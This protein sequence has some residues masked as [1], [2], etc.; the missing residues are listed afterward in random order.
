MRVCVWVPQ[1]V[2]DATPLVEALQR[3]H[4]PVDVTAVWAGDPHLRPRLPE[5]VR[6]S[7]LELPEPTGVG[8]GRLLVALPPDV[9]GWART[10]RALIRSLA[11]HGEPIVLLRGGSVGVQGSLAGLC[12]ASGATMVERSPDPIPDDGLAPSEG[13]L[14]RVGRWSD[15]AAAFA[16]DAV[17]LLD[18]LARVMAAGRPDDSAGSLLD[19]TV[20]RWAGPVCVAPD[21]VSAG[22]QVGPVA[23]TPH[24]VVVDE[25]DRDEPW[26]VRAG[27]DRPRTLLSG[28]P[29]LAATLTAT[30]AQWT[31]RAD[32]PVLPGGVPIDR[33]VRHLVHAAIDDWRRDA[34]ELPPQPFEG[35]GLLAWL[36]T[37][38]PE[39]GTGIG[40]YWVEEWRRR[41]DLH[42][43]FPDPAQADHAPFSHWARTSWRDGRSPLIRARSD[44]PTRWRDVGRDEG[45]NLIGHLASDLGLGEYARRILRALDAASVPTAVLHDERSS[46]PRSEDAPTT[47]DELRYDTN[48][49]VVRP[50]HL[51][52]LARDHG[53]EVFEGR[54]TIGYWFWELTHVP[55][56]VA[57]GAEAV[58]EIWVASEFVAD[59]F[60]RATTRPV[61]VVPIPI[62]EPALAELPRSHFSLPDDR[63]VFVVTFD[64]FSLTDR[65]N[66]FGAID[67]FGRA[68]PSSRPDGPILV[69]KTLNGA[70]RWLQHERL[71]LAAAGRDDIRVID[72]HL[73]RVEQMALVAASDALVSLHRSEGLGLHLMEAMW[74]GVP[75]IATRYSG[76]LQYMSDENAALVDARLVPVED[77]EGFYPPAA[78]WAEP[79][80]DAAASWMRRLVDDPSVGRAL[81]AAG[82]RTMMEQP[83]PAETGRLIAELARG[84]KEAS[85]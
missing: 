5:P 50:D 13:D 15:A 80:L 10:S 75:V 60:R 40:R 27:R 42:V 17:A 53:R 35:R 73:P 19:L 45:V 54:H 31:Y 38:A 64:H 72:G 33:V 79:D 4:D 58:D 65:K 6:W 29:V 9:Y 20:R 46:S 63:F 28:D 78:V 83:T 41:P 59:A 47:T 66:P 44:A 2:F 34:G 49:V 18:R 76:N 43:A 70:R 25:I 1:G 22:W 21:T 32:E 36:A 61:R 85:G 23:T 67:A 30:E 12:P 55:P 3:Y 62:P 24:L 48:I 57:A 77:R 11:E 14:A 51:P 7:D 69:I 39:A 74:L 82:R 81:A 71:R 84:S 68:F 16:P 26:H 52:L 37:P 8:W 56:D